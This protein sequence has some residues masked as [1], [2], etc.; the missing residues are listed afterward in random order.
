MEGAVGEPTTENP[1]AHPGIPQATVGRT[2]T[3][4]VS[5]TAVPRVIK[6]RT[7]TTPNLQRSGETFRG[8][9]SG[10]ELGILG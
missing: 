7:E 10:I 1:H 6:A 5:A 8:D 4:Y 3:R 9:A 2:V